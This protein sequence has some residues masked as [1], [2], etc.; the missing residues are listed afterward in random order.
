MGEPVTLREFLEQQFEHLE[1]TFRIEREAHAEI[2]RVAK[3]EV[4]RHLA[5]MNELQ[6]Q[7]TRE[8]ASYLTRQEVDA[9]LRAER[10]E[11]MALANANADRI[12]ALEVHASNMT[13]RVWMLTA[14]I[15]ILL[16]IFELYKGWVK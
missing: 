7:I 14:G 15:P 2:H 16:V 8:R 10:A 4:D 6:A 12:R 3:V 9:Q 1:E 11:Y 5:S 13:G